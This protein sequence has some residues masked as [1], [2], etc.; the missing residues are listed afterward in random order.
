MSSEALS[1]LQCDDVANSHLKLQPN[2]IE[3]ELIVVTNGDSLD[4]LTVAF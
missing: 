4:L 3:C 2:G 1:S